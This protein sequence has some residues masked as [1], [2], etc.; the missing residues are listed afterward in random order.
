M[1]YP[2]FQQKMTIIFF[3][4]QY[5]I[6]IVKKNGDIDL[7]YNLEDEKKDKFAEV[8]NPSSPSK[9]DGNNPKSTYILKSNRK[10]RH[11]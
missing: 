3:L 5:K 8:K 6:L 11:T 4:K 10:I 7:A 9:K 2:E 1:S